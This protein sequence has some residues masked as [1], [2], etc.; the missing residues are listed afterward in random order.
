MSKLIQVFYSDKFLADAL[1]NYWLLCE[2]EMP[3][4]LIFTTQQRGERAPFESPSVLKAD[5]DSAIDC[6]APGRWFRLMA[7]YR[8]FNK[9]HFLNEDGSINKTINVL[10]FRQQAI[11]RYHLLDQ[12]IE[13]T[14]AIQARRIMLKFLNRGKE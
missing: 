1:D 8:D 14:N 11:V 4:E 2:G 3:E 13:R 6:L 7:K 12:E 9:E 10:S 5:L